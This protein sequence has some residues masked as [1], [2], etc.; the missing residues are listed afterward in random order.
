MARKVKC[1]A[2]GEYGTTDTFVKIDGK[3][4]KDQLTYDMYQNIIKYRRKVYD[5]LSDIMGYVPGQVFPTIVCRKLKEL[6][7]YGYQCIYETIIRCRKDIDWFMTHKDFSS[8]YQRFAYLFAIIK[9]NIND[10][11]RDIKYREQLAE[12]AKHRQHIAEVVPIETKA[13][14]EKDVSRW[15]EDDD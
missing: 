3:W 1:H 15:V 13:R 7:M 9:N 2:S 14:A 8:D 6:N 11:Y 10:T 4:Y 12:R 5:E